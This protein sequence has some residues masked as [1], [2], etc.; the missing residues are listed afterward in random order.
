MTS[1][2]AEKPISDWSAVTDRLL[3]EHPLKPQQILDAS[4]SAWSRLWKTRVGDV[5]LGVPFEDVDPPA[6]VIGYFFEKL[7]AKELE[8]RL[9]NA[10]R[11]GRGSEKDLHCIP[12]PD[13]SVEMK[14]SGQLGS[15]IFGNRSYG[16]QVENA[17]AAKKDKS[18]YY[19]TVNFYGKTLTLIR[20][21]WI[22]ASDWKAQSSAT[23]QMAGLGEEVYTHKLRV[24][25]GKY[26]LNSPIKKLV[27]GVGDKAA[28]A[29]NEE[30]VFT[31]AGL[32]NASNLPTKLQKHRAKA[33][34]DYGDLLIAAS[35]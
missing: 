7:V 5:E 21:G 9:P 1:P 11:G 25:R 23:G 15:K 2:Y 34:E 33:I 19:I 35:E 16:Q 3:E 14:S 12:S 31:I 27:K 29:L 8:A 6:T 22:D 4:L 28:D 10:W 20:F 17:D 24:I 30:G 32:L 26:M 18:G 13:K